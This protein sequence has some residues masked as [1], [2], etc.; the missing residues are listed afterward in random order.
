M[1]LNCQFSQLTRLLEGFCFFTVRPHNYLPGPLIK[2]ARSPFYN[3][4]LVIFVTNI[5]EVRLNMYLNNKVIL[6]ICFWK[7]TNM[8]VRFLD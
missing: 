8:Q 7:R 1:V 5:Y 6:E 2:V 3:A 4:A